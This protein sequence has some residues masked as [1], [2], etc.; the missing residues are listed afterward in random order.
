MGDSLGDPN[1]VND[2]DLK[3]GACLRDGLCARVET[4]KLEMCW[5]LKRN[6]N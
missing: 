3:D 2:M 6:S 5:M 4:P 1:M